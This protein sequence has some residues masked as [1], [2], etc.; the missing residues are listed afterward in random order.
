MNIH[1]C[2]GMLLLLTAAAPVCAQQSGSV[3][4]TGWATWFESQ[5]AN[6]RPGSV[7]TGEV[8]FDL[9]SEFGFGGAVSFYLSSRF[10]TELGA[11]RTSSRVLLTAENPEVTPFEPGSLEI[12]PVSGTL[13][14]HFS[15]KSRIDPYLGAG[16][17]YVFFQDI[18]GGDLDGFDR[19]E[20]DDKVGFVANAGVNVWLFS[21]VG[22]SLDAKYIPLKSDLTT[23]FSSGA[24]E[25]VDLE[26]DPLILAA[27]VTVRF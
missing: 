9:D 27:G 10:S 21:Q 6:R 16:A 12:I 26:I 20:F 8:D 4:I 19:I 15:P 25:S 23:V 24:P 14:F 1:R 18:E 13:Q 17:A 22:L 7:E 11:S 2:V 5:G 3:A